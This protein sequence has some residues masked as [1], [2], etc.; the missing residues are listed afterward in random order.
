[1]N[2]LGGL[3]LTTMVL[4]CLGLASAFADDRGKLIGTWRLVAFKVQASDTK[5]TKD[6]LGPKP[7]GRLIL[8]ATG[9]ITNYRV[10]DGRKAAQT[11]AERSQLLLTMAAWTGRYRV[12]GNKLLIKIDSSW[13]ERETGAETTR[14]YAFE[15][16]KLTL[17]NVTPSSNFFAGRPAT[18][19]EIF[20]RED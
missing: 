13:N 3:A 11:D 18:G 2:R 15:G 14:T 7:G 17:S 20:E 16:D 4:L 8:T 9:Y 12:E 1:M 10:A 19:D 6:A 5:E